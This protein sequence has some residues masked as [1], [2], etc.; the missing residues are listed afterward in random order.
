MLRMGDQVYIE[1][2]RKGEFKNKNIILFVLLVIYLNLSSP[3]E[4]KVKWTCYYWDFTRLIIAI[5]FI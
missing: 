3:I 1:I 2:S 5:Y 4:A